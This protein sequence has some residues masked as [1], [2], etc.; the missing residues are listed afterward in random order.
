MMRNQM[1]NKMKLLIM[2]GGVLM[3][4]SSVVTL[5]VISKSPTNDRQEPASRN[6]IS[7]QALQRPVSRP[8]ISV[9]ESAFD[10]GT[11]I[12]G[13]VA[14]RSVELSNTG[15]EVLEILKISTSCGC[16]KAYLEDGATF[17]GPGQSKQLTITFDPAIHGDDSDVGDI[18]RVIYV[19]S[20]DPGKP[21]IEIDLSATVIKK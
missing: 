11:V 17:I 6:I 12:F 14:R 15:D 4:A 9:S 3:V 21:E 16:T 8:S 19:K 1:K 20:N 7:D 10:L 2:T 18:T 5:S 13:D